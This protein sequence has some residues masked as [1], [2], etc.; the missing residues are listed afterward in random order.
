MSQFVISRWW[1]RG[2]AAHAESLGRS[3][4]TAIALLG[5]TWFGVYL[6]DVAYWC[7]VPAE[8]PY[9]EDAVL[10]GGLVPVLYARRLGLTQHVPLFTRDIDVAVPRVSA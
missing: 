2:F 9:S 8:A 4:E 7:C 1:A 10:V 6:N 5:E 3:A